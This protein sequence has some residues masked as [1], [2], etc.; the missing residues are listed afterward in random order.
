MDEQHN[1]NSSTP[2]LDVAQQQQQPKRRS[3][4]LFSFMSAAMGVTGI[5]F[6]LIAMAL[7]HNKQQP[8]ALADTMLEASIEPAA[9]KPSE[10]APEDMAEQPQRWPDVPRYVAN[11][12]PVTMASNTMGKIAIVIDDMGEIEDRSANALTLPTPMTLSFLPYGKYSVD[13][14][15]QARIRGHEIMIH[16]PME[17][18]SRSAEEIINPG[19]NALFANAELD[20]ISSTVHTNIMHL[21]NF[22]VGVN[23]HMGSKFTE[24]PEGLNEV[25]KV[26]QDEGMFFL[27]SVTTNKSAVPIAATGLNLPVLKRDIFLDHYIDTSKIEEALAKVEQ[28]AQSQGYAI[29]IGHPHPQTVAALKAWAPTLAEKNLQLVPVSALLP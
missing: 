13:Q 21:K 11:A 10:P 18:H 23:N 7:H 28:R 6:L 4:R 19:P 12:V 24:W 20:S 9:G 3:T 22:S 8:E 17:P 15:F 14:A 26:V 25:F 2:L 27:D 29:A 5:A 16:L 1:A